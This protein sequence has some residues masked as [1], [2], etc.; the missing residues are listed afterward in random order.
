[1]TT[2]I[3]HTLLVTIILALPFAGD[4]FFVAGVPIYTPELL[5]IFACSTFLYI[6]WHT[7]SI[8]IR[9]LPT[10]IL[11]GISMIFAG[12]ISSTI[13]S[14]LSTVSLGIIKSW[15]LFPIV[16]FWLLF[17]TLHQHK[18][19]EKS[20]PAISHGN[21]EITRH[22]IIMYWFGILSITAC[23][24]FGYFVQNILTYD[25]RLKAFYLS[26]NQLALFLFP[27]VF[28]GQYLAA[29]YWNKKEYTKAFSICFLWA[30]LAFSIIAT[31]SFTVIG[32]C[33]ITALLFN[34]RRI[35]S[36]INNTKNK[37][38]FLFLIF[39][40]WIFWVSFPIL[41]NF[42][43]HFERSSLASRIMIWQ[44]SWKMIE[45]YPI[46]GIGPGNF[47]EIYLTYQQ[48]FP[49]YLDWA[50]PHPHNL[51]LAFWLQS[52]IFGLAG[53][54]VIITYFIRK[55]KNIYTIQ[56]TT[57][58]ASKKSHF[59]R[60]IVSI[61]IAILLIGIFDTPIW[62]NDLAYEF[63]LLMALGI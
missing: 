34:I 24:S 43:E 10:L 19:P 51:Y 57:A 52:G 36:Y 53:F 1:M 40:S 41:L 4:H 7:Y 38:L 25:G 30:L 26:P 14:G 18:R 59:S 62:K 12:L 27:G 45:N 3:L 22:E 20:S 13:A 16:Y 35:A 2:K 60:M 49:P 44:S 39:C 37:W 9:K 46:L 11:I 17:Q 21:K 61:F 54:C 55:Y 32:A 6:V 5:L 47:Q 58:E 63:W 23:I 48:Y 31:H 15:F 29:F 33:I 56:S 8:K 50:V 28:I 42:S